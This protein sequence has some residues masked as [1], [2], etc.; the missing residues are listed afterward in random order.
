MIE[1]GNTVRFRIWNGPFGIESNCPPRFKRL[2]EDCVTGTGIV[3]DKNSEEGHENYLLKVLDFS[4]DLAVHQRSTKKRDTVWVNE[5]EIVGISV[6]MAM[7][8]KGGKKCG[9]AE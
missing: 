3:I 6:D 2:S 5:L 4:G 1:V 8:E 9:N 7:I